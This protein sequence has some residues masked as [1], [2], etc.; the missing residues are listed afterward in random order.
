MQ[1][2]NNDAS[3]RW[4]KRVGVEPT[5]DG[6]TRR[7]PV[8]KTVAVTGRRALP[9]KSEAIPFQR[10]ADV[11][12]HTFGPL[13]SFKVLSFKVLDM[14]YRVGPRKE[15]P[16]NDSKKAQASDGNGIPRERSWCCRCGL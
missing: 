1:I 14:Y 11:G 16:R 10:L 6:G 15:G 4:R 12:R 9:R 7:P 13:P 2:F 8:L 5:G 3:L